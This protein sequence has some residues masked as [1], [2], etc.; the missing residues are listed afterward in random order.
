MRW[1]NLFLAAVILSGAALACE[2]CRSTPG[3]A[4]K[5]GGGGL[6]AA[7]NDLRYRWSFDTSFDYRNWD[8][9]DADKAKSLNDIGNHVHSHIDDWFITARVGYAV[10][11]DI[12]V[13]VSQNYRHLRTIN[14]N[15][16]L[17]LGRHE[18]ADGFGDLEFDFKYRFKEQKEDGFPVDLA[19]F[20]SVKPPTGQSNERS[21][22]TDALFAAHDQPSAG[23]LNV[24]GGVSASKQ[25]GPWGAS[26]AA[27]FTYKGEGAQNFREGNTFRLTFSA[28]RELPWQ[29]GGWK[30]YP[31]LGVQTLFEFQGRDNGVVDE[32]HGGQFISV[33]P[34]FVA[35]PL[36]RLTLSAGIT[37]PVYQEYNGTHQR[38]DF[39]VMIGIGVRF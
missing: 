34:S 23:A 25:W 3:D 21:E 19:I 37:L 7:G 13:G 12:S 27:I 17:L 1:V 30:F 8:R 39:G 24:T 14:V 6:T 26:G 29:P 18:Y 35:K 20:V 22:L 9:I 10:N 36:D 16:L 11:R 15:D 32:D 28:S 31:T 38:T 5:G 2:Q 4:S 33:V